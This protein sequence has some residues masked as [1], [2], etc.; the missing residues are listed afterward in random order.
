MISSE[1][2]IPNKSSQNSL[3]EYSNMLEC[4]NGQR[5]LNRKDSDDKIILIIFKQ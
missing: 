5:N 1:L 4:L 2:T 3:F